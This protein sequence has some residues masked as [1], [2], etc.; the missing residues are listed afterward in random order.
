MRNVNQ[1][2]KNKLC[3][4]CSICV[5]V[6]PLRAIDLRVNKLGLYTPFVDETKCIKCGKCFQV[7]SGKGL[8]LN[9]APLIK[10]WYG[11]SSDTF[12]RKEGQS[13]G[14]VTQFLMHAFENDLITGALVLVPDKNNPFMPKAIIARSR[15]EILN[16]V[17]SRYCPSNWSN[18][19]NFVKKDD[20]LAV[21]G[22]PCQFKGLDNFLKLDKSLQDKIVYKF[23][24]ICDGNLSFNFIDFVLEYLKLKR[25]EIR[26]FVYRDKTNGWP[27]EMKINIRGRILFKPNSLRGSLKMFFL[28]PRCFICFDKLNSS[29]DLVFGDAYLKYLNDKEKGYSVVSARTRKGFELV[30]NVVKEKKSILIPISNGDVVDCQKVELKNAKAAY[31]LYV[32]K[33]IS[34][35]DFKKEIPAEEYK[36][37]YPAT[38]FEKFSAYLFCYTDYLEILLFSSKLFLKLISRNYFMWKTISKTRIVKNQLF[39]GIVKGRARRFKE[40]EN[41]F[42]AGPNE[43]CIVGGN[44]INKGAEAMTRVVV[45]YFLRRYSYKSLVIVFKD[46]K[47]KIFNKEMEEYYDNPTKIDFLL[48]FVRVFLF[49]LFK[50]IFFL[51]KRLRKFNEAKFFIDIH[52]YHLHNGRNF[53]GIFYSLH[54]ILLAKLLGKKYYVF[55]QSVDYLRSF[56]NRLQVRFF[57]YLSDGIYVRG[58]E[59]KKNLSKMTSRSI[60]V[61]PDIAF[62]FPAGNEQLDKILRENNVYLS[63][64]PLIGIIPNT[65]LYDK[66]KRCIEILSALVEKL[67]KEGNYQVILLPHEIKSGGHD[68]LT[69]CREIYGAVKVENRSN[70][71]LI[72]GRNC[73]ASVLK[74]IISLCRI[75]VSSRFHGAVAALSQNIPAITLAWSF[76]YREL[77]CWFD[78][79]GYNI[80]ES[81]LHE[82]KIFALVKS[83]EDDYRNIQR[84]LEVKNK[85][86]KEEVLDLFNSIGKE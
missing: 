7:C 83:I 64:R 60:V 47:E 58:A 14:L 75:V 44:F 15:E 17:K 27:G 49:S 63:R 10:S 39:D 2:A 24:L 45:D 72:E 56:L 42:S 1:V 20:R 25:E 73:D 34:G 86:I 11:Y 13:G 18:A 31:Y 4:G 80:D 81:E 77:L 16:S 33:K 71:H 37:Y 5:Q 40:A 55:P 65:N 70:L 79:E 84:Q 57:F 23:G 53:K 9:D 50:K 30:E 32:Y 48:D 6:C 74:E 36:K 78:F 22:L 54:Y 61:K 46:R 28:N 76:K 3:T 85:E 21:V 62:L 66:N 19:L 8:F 51:S 82:Q 43:V 38:F 41:Q 35:V 67:I 12:I 68:D 69:V 29:A 52:G 26:E 59:S